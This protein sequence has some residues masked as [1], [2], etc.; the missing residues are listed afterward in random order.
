MESERVIHQQ[1]KD[2][3][4]RRQIKDLQDELQSV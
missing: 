4:M 3:L 1:E 2:V